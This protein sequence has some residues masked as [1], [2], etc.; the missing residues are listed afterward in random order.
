M[1]NKPN[2]EHAFKWS[3]KLLEERNLQ[4]L[5]YAIKEKENAQKAAKQGKKLPKR[6]ITK[7]VTN[8]LQRVKSL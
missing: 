5:D 7:D 3:S 2:I 6:F 4:S 8:Y 1:A